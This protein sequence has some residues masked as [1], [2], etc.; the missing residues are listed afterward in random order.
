MSLLTKVKKQFKRSIIQ[1]V[2]IETLL[3]DDLSKYNV[4][5]PETI[6]TEEAPKMV[7]ASEA[8]SLQGVSH[9]TP[10]AY[11]IVLEDVFY[12]PLYSV[13]LTK[14]RKIICES[15]NITKPVED[16]KLDCL[17]TSKVEDISGYSV[18]WHHIKPRII[19]IIRLS[20]IYPVFI[21]LPYTTSF[22]IIIITSS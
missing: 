16:F 2:S 18:I 15:F 20:I 22:K 7:F 11:T 21:S 5:L 9:S 10:L 19:T 6:A 8:T 4:V 1:S 14:D 17:F 12:C 3:K 13:I